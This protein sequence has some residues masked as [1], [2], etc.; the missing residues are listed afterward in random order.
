MKGIHAKSDIN[1]FNDQLDDYGLVILN[2]K[3]YSIV[4]AND[5]AVGFF[6]MTKVQLL[7]TH[8]KYFF[9]DAGKDVLKEEIKKLHSSDKLDLLFNL[10]GEK[11]NKADAC[12]VHVKG[13]KLHLAG[14]LYFAFIFRKLHADHELEIAYLERERRF[15]ILA[16]YTQSYEWQTDATG[17]MV[18]VSPAVSQ[19]LG[20]SPEEIIGKMY[21]S[22]FFP[23]ADKTEFTRKCDAWFSSMK[24]FRNFEN[25]ARTREGKIVWLSTSGYPLVGR[26]GELL[27]YWGTDT[28]ITEKKKNEEIIR[29]KTEAIETSLSAI[30]ICTPEGDWVSVNQAFLEMWG[31]DSQEEVMGTN[32][33]GYFAEPE[34]AMQIHNSLGDKGVYK[35]E[36]KARR[37]NGEVFSARLHASLLKDPQNN[38][39]YYMASF[40]DIT[41]QKQKQELL[42]VKDKAFEAAFNG[43]IL[44][45]FNGVLFYVNKRFVQMWGYERKEEILGRNINEFAKYPERIDEIIQALLQKG[46]YRGNETGLK[47]DQR[48]FS[49]RFSARLVKND[50][51]TPI[52]LMAVIDDISQQQEYEQKLLESKIRLETLADKTHD[53]ELWV[54]PDGSIEYTSPSCERITGYTAKELYENPALLRKMKINEDQTR[55]AGFPFNDGILSEK[56]YYDIRFRIFT[57]SRQ[58]RWVSCRG[59]QIFDSRGEHLGVRLSITDIHEMVQL[60]NKLLYLTIEVEEKERNRISAEL[61]DSLGPLLSSVKLCYELLEDYITDEK[62]RRIFSHGYKSLEQAIETSRNTVN[63]LS[64]RLLD[65]YGFVNALNNFICMLNETGKIKIDFQYNQKDKFHHFTEVNLYRITTELINNTIKHGKANQ[66]YIDFS[67]KKG[68]NEIALQYRDDGKG[69]DPADL[70]ASPGMGILNIKQRVKSLGGQVQF[71]NAYPSGVKATLL[72]PVKRDF[73]VG[74]RIEHNTI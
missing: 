30:V 53:W 15:G 34:V 1:I 40:E 9:P 50:E 5:Y 51:G 28:N 7:N 36:I 65:K 42:L 6:G 66:I 68:W 60:E 39:L 8:P 69:F 49:V 29:L 74:K 64:P 32:I 57:K 19:V 59:G 73:Q 35:G 71:E 56:D 12:L 24:P 10:S 4:E 48:A 27:G 45:D 38:M 61:H 25:P 63:M 2:G 16:E 18:N 20:Y 72:I 52:C 44:T 58:I 23:F 11:C 47:N 14:N 26:Y 13:Q 62:T 37:K 31:Y 54:K 17:L 22:D 41:E 70:N 21:F 33:L 46:T 43:F 55:S 67:V 3:T